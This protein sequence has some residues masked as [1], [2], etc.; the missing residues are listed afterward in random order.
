MPRKRVPAYLS[1]ADVALVPLRK[2]ELF[3]AALPSKIFDAWAAGCPTLV[4]IDGEARRVLEESGAGRFAEP[5]SP[6]AL[7]EAIRALADDREA[8]R[9]MGMNGRSFVKT[10]FSRQSQA[11]VLEGILRGVV[12]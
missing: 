6:R 5:E 10:H 8:C 3:A 11:S 2:L 7:V 9:E 1:A 12:E 4:S